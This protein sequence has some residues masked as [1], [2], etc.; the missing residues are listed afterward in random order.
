M[1]SANRKDTVKSANLTSVEARG[2]V[3]VAAARRGGEALHVVVGEQ[4]I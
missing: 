4:G 3:I 2:L 1:K